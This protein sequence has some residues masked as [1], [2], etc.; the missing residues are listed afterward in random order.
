MNIPGFEYQYNAPLKKG[1][2]VS[3]GNKPYRVQD[4]GNGWL[5]IIVQTNGSR[6]K[7]AVK[8]LGTAN[9][10]YGSQA[11]YVFNEWWKIYPDYYLF[12][13]FAS[14]EISWLTQ[15]EKTQSN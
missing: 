7:I 8:E 13:Q 10:I 4:D 1:D 9:F 5:H 14:A 2:T 11:D 12:K 6:K 3:Y 15:W